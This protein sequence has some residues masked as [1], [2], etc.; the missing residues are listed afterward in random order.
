MSKPNI[1]KIKTLDPRDIFKKEPDF[2]Q[3][4]NGNLD[5]L[6]EL[7]GVDLQDGT[8]EVDVGTFICDIVAKDFDSGKSVIIENQFEETDHDH[9]GKI[10][11]YGAGKDAG[12]IIW[13]SPEFQEEHIAALD[14]LNRKSSN[15]DISFFGVQIKFIQIDDSVPAPDFTILVKPN[16]WANRVKNYNKYDDYDKE[17]FKLY[18]EIVKE[19]AKLDTN[20]I[21]PIIKRKFVKWGI[22]KK[23]FH[24]YW[25][26]YTKNGFSLVI[27]NMIFTHNKSKDKVIF[28]ELEKLKPILEKEIGEKLVFEHTGRYYV[29]A[30]H[31]L[32]SDIQMLST[33]E[34]L[35]SIQWASKTMKKFNEVFSKYVDSFTDLR[36]NQ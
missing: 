20:W 17:L 32:R 22:I 30:H 4:L 13:I 29:T 23:T 26:Y 27:Y 15:E 16:N 25:Q 31:N 5:Y 2:T 3:W 33:D 12:I 9:L 6:S 1:S 10:I 28:T 36:V 7:L 35:E 8:A 11:T 21:K 19:Y 24:L 18:E 14:W 34:K